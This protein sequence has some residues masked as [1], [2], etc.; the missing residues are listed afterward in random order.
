MKT[1]QIARLTGQAPLLMILSKARASGTPGG[2]LDFPE[3]RDPSS[4]LSE[5]EPKDGRDSL[6]T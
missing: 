2:M 3:R 5:S 4:D 1:V 6:G